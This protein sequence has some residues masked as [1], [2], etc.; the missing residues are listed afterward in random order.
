MGQSP[1]PRG[2]DGEPPQRAWYWQPG[3]I[4]MVPGTGRSQA[5]DSASAEIT[6]PDS[7]WPSGARDAASVAPGSIGLGVVSEV[8]SRPLQPRAAPITTTQWKSFIS[9]TEE[10]WA[11]GGRNPKRA[12]F[13][14]TDSCARSSGGPVHAET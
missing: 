4:R 12:I 8:L 3:G 6:E 7:S 1:G 14:A 2:F 10:N 5:S 13:F 9:R 11:G